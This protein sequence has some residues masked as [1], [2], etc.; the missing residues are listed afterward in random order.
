VVLVSINANALGDPGA[1]FDRVIA[2]A[3]AI[4]GVTNAAQAGIAPLDGEYAWT[5]DFTI[6]GRPP[7]E[8]GVELPHF[9]VSPEYFATLRVP[10]R[11]GRL[12]GADDRKDTPRVVLI[13]ET[14]A[15]T[16]FAG[17]DPIGQ[18]LCFEKT[19]SPACAWQTIIGVVADLHETSLEK[20]PRPAVFGSTLQEAFTAGGIMLRTTGDPMLVVP[21][22][23]AIIRELAPDLPVSSV[24]TL[25]ALRARSLAR[26]RFFATV[27]GVFAVVGLTLATV[28]VYGVVA[29]LARARTRE[30]G[31]RIAL[32]AQSS[33]VMSLLVAHGLR[34]TIIGLVIG[35]AIALVATRAM[36][37]LLF[38]VAPNDPL[39][40]AVVA[41]VL[42]G[43]SVV[44]SWI[45]ALR[46][47]RG[48]PMLSLRMD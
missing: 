30:M 38:G 46:A 37:A 40:L 14:F 45:P 24:R 6:R 25:D 13:N 23:R 34:L 27:L 9:S 29:Q 42:M 39:T 3:R 15:R 7:G 32:G 2:R 10:L 36:A 4:P 11:R 17:R 8:Y 26:T 21:P 12:F 31:I 41:V 16:Y 43:A 19:P 44:A 18:S 20:S 22:L 5:S 33:Q 35:G 1:F 48:D 47:S 28:G